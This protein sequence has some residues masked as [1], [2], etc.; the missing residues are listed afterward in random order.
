MYLSRQAYKLLRFV[1]K[2][3]ADMIY[4]FSFKCLCSLQRERIMQTVIN[5]KVTVLCY[6]T[7]MFFLLYVGKDCIYYYSIFKL[8]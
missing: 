2:D 8:L 6:N 5:L 4:F 7:I 1:V 3:R